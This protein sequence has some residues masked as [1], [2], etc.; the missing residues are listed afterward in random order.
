ME[1]VLRR[2]RKQKTVLGVLPLN[3]GWL[4][5]SRQADGCVLLHT[6]SG[7]SLE[8]LLSHFAARI[9]SGLSFVSA[10][11]Q[12]QVLCHRISMSE[13]LSFKDRDA[14]AY[15]Q[16]QQYYANPADNLA[17][18]AVALGP[19]MH[20]SAQED[21]LLIAAHK[22]LIQ[23]TMGRYQAVGFSLAGLDIYACAIARFLQHR[24]DAFPQA[25]RDG[26]T[27]LLDIGSEHI[28]VY[29]FWRLAPIAFFEFSYGA[30]SLADALPAKLQSIFGPAPVGLWILSA[31]DEPFAICDVLSH[32]SQLALPK[33]MFA[34]SLQAVSPS[35]AHMVVYGCALYGAQDI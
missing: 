29:C 35:I 14:L 24:Q 21:V 20:S 18:D 19:S 26:P 2:F 13:R 23:Q 25:F 7:P 34:D 1:V 4:A 32:L 27:A 31:Q 28:A 16:A 15:Y 6:S 9:R 33:V 3:D 8:G 12:Q 22:D 11:S 5:A 17:V 10:L 30:E